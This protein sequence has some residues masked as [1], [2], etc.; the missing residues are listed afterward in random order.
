MDD[1][2]LFNQFHAGD[3][4]AGDEIIEKHKGLVLAYVKKITRNGAF[5]DLRED[6][7]QSGIEGL[8]TARDRFELKRGNK[9]STH[10]YPWI[11]KFVLE[12]IKRENRFYDLHQ[13]MSADNTET[14]KSDELLVSLER[15]FGYN[16]QLAD[17]VMLWS[18][19]ETIL[20]RREFDICRLIEQGYTLEEIG[21]LH[22]ISPQRIHQLHKR[23]RIK[24]QQKII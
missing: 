9:F 21:R 22:E 10:A 19:L 16:D 15:K 3:K 17:Y 24:I 8:I 7:I 23:S 2:Q 13:L 20:T 11:L 18:D 4:E 1:V 12:A 6:L 14:E 5:S